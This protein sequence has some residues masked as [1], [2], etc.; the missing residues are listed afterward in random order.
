MLLVS[1]CSFLHNPHLF[2]IAFS[3]QSA[4]NLARSGAGNQYIASSV[5]ANLT[6]SV[7]K[8]FILWSGLSR[9]DLPLSTKLNLDFVKEHHK[10]II[11]NTVWVH[12]GGVDGGVSHD[13][14]PSWLAGYFKNQYLP[15][16]WDHLTNQS[17]TSISGCLNI[18]EQQ[19]INYFFGFIYD[20]YH[21]YSDRCWL[22]G[23]VNPNNTLLKTIPWHRCI[24]IT[25]YEFCLKNDQ[26]EED[27]IH[28]TFLGYQ[29]WWNAVKDQVS[30]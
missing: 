19:K 8:V 20:I 26:L 11:D 28:P 2:K 22:G 21:D 13:P 14:L 16:D 25:P 23:R 24:S 3:N 4:I 27:G 7:D 5:L 9:V 30:F 1:G 10:T 17:L 15:F 6:P 18:L 29:S 12:S